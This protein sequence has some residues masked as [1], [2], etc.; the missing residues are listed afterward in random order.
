METFFRFYLAT[1][2]A[3]STLAPT[4]GMSCPTKKSGANAAKQEKKVAAAPK[5]APTRGVA[6]LANGSA[7]RDMKKK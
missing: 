3:A 5:S 6:S 2:L 7:P 4:A 1:V